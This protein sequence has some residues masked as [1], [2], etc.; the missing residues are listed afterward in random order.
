MYHVSEN[1][2]NV[3]S[4]KGSNEVYKRIGDSNYGPLSISE[5]DNL[6]YD[7]NLRCF[8]DQIVED[9]DTEDFDL[10]HTTF[11]TY[12]TFQQEFYTLILNVYVYSYK[13]QYS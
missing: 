11:R 12:A 6:R 8:E 10:Q 7:K 1:N 9:F 5:I 4:R 3:F 13:S 2:E